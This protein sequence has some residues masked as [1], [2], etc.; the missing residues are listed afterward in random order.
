[1]RRHEMRGLE[2]R[3]AQ[4]TNQTVKAAEL[5]R[6]YML[7]INLLIASAEH[8][9]CSMEMRPASHSCKYWT[10]T[11]LLKVVKCRACSGAKKKNG[12]RR[13]TQM[14]PSSVWNA[15]SACGAGCRCCIKGTVLR[16]A[17]AFI[18]LP[19][20]Q[21]SQACFDLAKAS[22]KHRLKGTQH[23]IVG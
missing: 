23:G 5:L 13:L 12:S 11:E 16:V 20:Q 6:A 3:G 8:S 15:V 21:A 14:V 9:T 22:G 18:T 19:L 2:M 1:M 10:S 17:A 4:L 7:G